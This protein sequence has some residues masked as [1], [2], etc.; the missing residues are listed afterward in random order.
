LAEVLIH[1]GVPAVLGMRDSI[2]DEEALSFIQILAEELAKRRTIDQAVAEAR[3]QL[4]TL[5]RFNQPAW[6]LPVLYMHPEFNG[7]LLRQLEQDLTKLPGPNLPPGQQPTACVRSL[8]TAKVWQV[9]G[10]MIRVGRDRSENDLV[11]EEDQG[12]ISR[13][14]ADI[15]CRHAPGEEPTEAIYVLEDISR[16]GTWVLGAEGWHRVHRQEVPLRS[17]MQIKFG[18]SQN[19]AFEFMIHRP[20]S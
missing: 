15:F 19:E 10:G 6:T 4:L 12:G 3:R 9:R 17:G 8:K 7:E 16:F 2:T 5:Y 18:S 11:L 1:H 20:S 13:R 14:H